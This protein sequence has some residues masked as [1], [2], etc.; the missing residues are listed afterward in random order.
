MNCHF[1]V[2]GMAMCSNEKIADF[3]FIFESISYGLAKI[4]QG[5]YEPEV[6]ISDVADSI[7]NV[8]SNVFGKKDM[9]MCWTHMLWNVNKKA[10]A[11]VNKSHQDELIED[12]ETLQKSQNK[13]IFKKASGFFLK[14]WKTLE[15]E[16]S[17]YFEAEWLNSNQ[18]W[19]EGF[20]HFTPSTNNALESFNRVVKDEDT[21]RE[22][23]LFLRFKEV[24]LEMVA[25]WSNEY[26]TNMK[27]YSREA[28]ITL[29]LWTKGY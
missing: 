14:K 19:Y 6:L 25:K 29:N 20:R 1:H 10:E 12:I 8:F 9:V 2:F 26:S 11:M 27:K 13:E 4:N 22:R 5:E 28:T 23:H 7:R 3:K 21:L 24:A 18:T 17:R 16:F 15:P